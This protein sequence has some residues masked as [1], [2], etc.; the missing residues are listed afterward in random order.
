VIAS[1]RA[2]TITTI[3]ARIQSNSMKAMNAEQTMI[4]SASGSIRMPKLVINFRRRA[5]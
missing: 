5:I 1:S 2:T 4:L 3:H